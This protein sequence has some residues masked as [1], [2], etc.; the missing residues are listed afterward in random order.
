MFFAR[1]RKDDSKLNGIEI[2]RLKNK[3]GTRQLPTAELLLDGMNAF[4]VIYFYEK[5][6]FFFLIIFKMSEIGK[7]V[8]RMSSM[9]NIT[10]IHNSLNAIAF[11][12]RF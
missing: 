6:T 3:L 5:I 10:R 2:Q 8:S 7:G 11:M 4:R 12:R 9:L 1:I